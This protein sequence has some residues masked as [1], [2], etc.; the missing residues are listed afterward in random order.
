MIAA[1]PERLDANTRLAELPVSE[2]HATATTSTVELLETFENDPALPG[3][4]VLQDGELQAVISRSRLLEYISRPF[5]RDVGHRRSVGEFL[6]HFNLREFLLLPAATR[7]HD[8]ASLALVRN[9]AQIYE[10]V[11]VQFEPGRWGLIDIRLLMRAQTRIFRGQIDGHQQLVESTRMAEAK[12]RS[13]FENSIEGIF[14]TTPEGQYLSVNPALA[15]IYGYDSPE[16]LIASITDIKCQ[17]YV[18]PRRRQEFA[19]I[20]H[21]H[22]TVSGF[23]SEIYRRDQSIIWISENARAVRN[24]F[25]AIQYYEGSVEDITSRKQAEELHR[26]KEAAEAASRAKSEFLANMSHEIRTPLNGVIGMIDLLSGTSIDAQQQRYLRVARASADALLSLIN[27]VLDFSKIEAGKL[28]LDDVDFDLHALVEDISEMFAQRVE[29]QGLELAV[30]IEPVV[31][32]LVRGDPDRLRQVLVNLVNNAVKFTERG[33]VVVRVRLESEDAESAVIAMSVADT[34]IGIPA[35]R[36]D[37]LF[38]SFSQVDSSTTRK[39]GGTGLGL[40]VCKQLVE[41][42][43]GAID[44]ES[45]PGC[46][47]TFRF[48][49][50]LKKQPAAVGRPA[51]SHDLHG[52]RV[53]IVDDNATNREILS[54]QMAGWRFAHAG[55]ENAAVAL[56]MLSQAVA[57]GEPFRLAILD[58]QMPEMDGLELVAQIK[59]RPELRGTLLMML[60]SMGESMP[61]QRLQ[62]LGLVGYLTKPV[63]QSRLFD[64]IVNACSNPNAGSAER[65]DDHC[66]PQGAATVDSDKRPVA[67]GR[68]ILLAEDNEVNQLVAS[69][70]LRRLGFACEIV[71]NG[72]LALEAVQRGGFDLVLMDCQMPDLD[73]FEATG[74]IRQWE[75]QSGRPRLPIV[76]L[77]ANAVKGDRQ[78]CLDA[79]MDGYVSKPIDTPQLIETIQALLEG[80]DVNRAAAANEADGGDPQPSQPDTIDSLSMIERCLGDIEFCQQLL[81]RFTE[82]ASER[83]RQID[84]AAQAGNWPAL[85]AEAHAL[86]GAA[87]N[88]SAQPLRDAAQVLERLSTEGD[89]AAVPAALQRL[90]RE[91]Q[92]F[93]EELPATLTHLQS[94]SPSFAG[95]T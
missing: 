9:E 78:R 38:K 13:I 2:F 89:T 36:L 45:Q 65:M 81:S 43:G 82:Q 21:R 44:V 25:G 70:I 68:R 26:Q 17:L 16:A 35:D 41:L 71:S 11:V 28:E 94:A 31:P 3:A 23:E 83:E 14:Q 77:T 91:I 88:L 51:P 76:A 59:Q 4:I 30:V 67:S 73:G 6:D 56:A 84:A 58:M 34:G 39:Y 54:Q 95:E 64:A 29:Q 47:S 20:M 33:E 52:L 61:A 27:D 15:R 19:E 5:W 69:A 40:A 53:L 62:S 55:A 79:G 18:D 22:G 8:A 49:V 48:T 75:Q 63:R 80:D 24:A 12:Y 7:V 42:Q 86:K 93:E 60:T 92:R 90:R 74:L 46:G 85:A 37:R 57:A 66:P 10:P 1:L 87:A 72:R 32:T 50:R